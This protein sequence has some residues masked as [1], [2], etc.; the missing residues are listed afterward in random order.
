MIQV[1]AGRSA[2][3]NV[4]LEPS[5]VSATLA[6]LVI[7]APVCFCSTPD[8]S[9]SGLCATNCSDVAVQ[10]CSPDSYFSDFTM[11]RCQSVC[12]KSLG[13]AIGHLQQLQERVCVRLC[14]SSPSIVLESGPN[15]TLNN[16]NIQTLDIESDNG[17]LVCCSSIEA[18]IVL[19]GQGMHVR[20]RNIAF[21]R[22]SPNGT[23]QFINLHTNATLEDLQF[24]MSG[25]S[26]VNV[27]GS[28]TIVNTTVSGLSAVASSG[29]YIFSQHLPPNDS[30]SLTLNLTKCHFINNTPSTGNDIAQIPTRGGGMLIS[31]KNTGNSN[32][33]FISKCIFA[34]N[35]AHLGGGI[36][37]RASSASKVY[38]MIS[39]TDFS[40]NMAKIGSAIDF[41]CS[42]IPVNNTRKSCLQVTVRDSRF[43]SNGPIGE[44]IQKTS[45]TV[46]TKKTEIEFIGEVKF[47]N[48]NGSAVLCVNSDLSVNRNTTLRF[49]HNLAQQGA[50][51][52]LVSSY[53]HLYRNTTVV[54]SDNRAII[55]GGAIYSNQ[56]WDLYVPYSH[57]CF[58]E[59]DDTDCIP[60]NS[61][62][63][64]NPNNWNVSLM[65]KTNRALNGRTI[66]TVSLLPCLW[67]I[68]SESDMNKDL[69]AVF[70]EW[71]SCH[72]T[73]NCTEGD[74]ATAPSHFQLNKYELN[75]TISGAPRTYF[76]MNI[77]VFDELRNNVTNHT[78]F[79]MLPSKTNQ[80][81]IVE[82][83]YNGHIVV[84]G[85][86]P[87]TEE[88]YIQTVGERSVTAA[89]TINMIACPPGFKYDSKV[90][91]CVCRILLHSIVHCLPS[92]AAQIQIAYCMSYLSDYN[93]TIVY[94]RCIFTTERTSDTSPFIN[95]PQ[96]NDDVKEFCAKLNRTGL[97]C[98][99]CVSNFSVDVYSDSFQCSNCSGSAL[100]WIIFIAV[101]SIPIFVLFTVVVALHISLTSGPFNG[102]IFSC[103]VVTVTMEVIVTRTSLEKTGVDHPY[104]MTN[105]LLIP[106]NIWSLDFFRAYKIFLNKRPMCLG[107]NLTVMHLLALRYLT[108]FY[109]LLFLIVSYILTELHAR[110][111]RCLV[112][113]WSPVGYI[114]SRFRRTC[115]IRTSLVDAFATFILLSYVKIIRVSLLL[116]TYN[117]VNN[118]NSSIVM[119]VLHYDPTIPYASIEHFPFMVVSI[120]LLVTF[121]LFFPLTL[122]LYQFRFLQKCLHKLQANRNGLRIFMDAFQG[123]YKDGKDNGPDRRFFAGLYFVFRILV[124]GTFNLFWKNK[125]L[126]LT[127]QS[128]M[129][130]FAL[131]TAILRPYKRELYNIMDTFFFCVLGVVFG[132][133]VY[134]FDKAETAL[135]VPDSA[136]YVAYALE[137]IP[138]FYVICYMGVWVGKRLFNHFKCCYSL[139][140]T[141]LDNSISW[142]F[143]DTLE[144]TTPLVHN[145]PVPINISSEL[146]SSATQSMSERRRRGTL[147][148]SP[149]E[150]TISSVD[151]D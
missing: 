131:I 146:L 51:L 120:L 32:S 33:I 126:Y 68:S 61:T 78:L 37:V 88:W 76:S 151:S 15:N 66:F 45:S 11:P 144:E 117:T 148:S 147:Q 29:L 80:A 139:R 109:P 130:L 106:S 43:S 74:V 64:C 127:L 140:Y 93:K 71:R 31:L 94:G 24:K 81:L 62:A 110:N 9:S 121:G 59:Y 142:R 84:F 20:I 13:D 27:T 17:S 95:L 4:W 105:F 102:Y 104:L 77:T 34:N 114:V 97:L 82:P 46:N 85:E 92:K 10:T 53:V 132:L 149:F 111:C 23:L 75:Y 47:T 141:P 3:M 99:N 96:N 90:N 145:G 116:S 103:Q 73:P 143:N 122:I 12:F 36:S 38:L 83:N 70:C 40:G 48:N 115:D 98:G 86:G 67:K 133:H 25:L 55:A 137:F 1:R 108:A 57:K 119:K 91:D 72:F 89:M 107:S 49:T 19:S 124:F 42:Q 60:E 26:L 138:F 5:V 123:C 129:I 56:M 28:V 63:P 125:E 8:C 22:C 65:F 58:I 118:L 112:R 100:H 54:F 41:Y 150:N 136:V 7:V 128:L 134:V 2:A 35:S 39:D 18:K 52:N 6:V 21:S 79:N 69:A 87:R 113:V 14:I 44:I 101:E 30:S 135:V 50:G 16:S